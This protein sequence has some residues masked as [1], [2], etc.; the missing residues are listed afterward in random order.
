MNLQ[1]PLASAM[2]EDLSIESTT[3]YTKHSVES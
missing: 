2:R 1:F 3:V